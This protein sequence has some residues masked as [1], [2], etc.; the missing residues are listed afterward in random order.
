MAKTHNVLIPLLAATALVAVG[1]GSS[2]PKAVPSNGVAVVASQTITKAD[3]DRLI[4]QAKRT[5]KQQKRDFPKAGTPE[6]ATLRRQALDFLIQRAEFEQEAEKLG[7]KITDKQI[8]ERL[9]QLKD[10]FYEGKEERYQKAISDLGLSDEQ[11]RNDVR[12]QLIEEKIFE[13]ITAAV[14]ISDKQIQDHYNKNKQ[15]YQQAASRD[16]RHILVKTKKTADDLHRQ[17][18]N[19]G[20]FA[21][22]AKKHS[23]DPGSKGQGGKLTV[24]RGQ[25]VPEFDKVAFSLKK[26][27]LAKPVKTQ[28][29]WHIIEALTEVKAATTTPFAQVKEAIRQQLLQQERTQ[30]MRDWVEDT[31]ADYADEIGYQV[32]YEPP[33]TD[34]TATTTG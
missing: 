17:L 20:N 31:K 12:A 33:K 25:T 4:E 19:G 3:F 7:I 5:A 18:T 1:C 16:V 11:V 28:Y 26:G 23:Q 21:A 2:D 29:G 34:T 9:K 14:K 22:L 27:E 15:Q 30:A 32:G 24:T 8:D 10:Q 13:K 6:Y